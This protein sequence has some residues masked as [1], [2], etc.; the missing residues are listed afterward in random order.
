M[1]ASISAVR[2]VVSDVPPQGYQAPPGAHHMPFFFEPSLTSLQ[3][4]QANLDELKKNDQYWDRR[5][6]QLQRDHE[7]IKDIMDCEYKKAV[8]LIEFLVVRS[9][10]F[11]GFCVFFF[12]I[13][14]VHGSPKGAGD[15]KKMKG[16]P[17]SIKKAAVLECYKQHPNEP[18]LCAKEVSAFTE[19]VDNC[20][21]HFVESRS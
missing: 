17:C 3:I 14:E 18:M 13:A 10:N 12:Q 1:F 6:K 7:Q 15:A 2:P 8:S 9:S 19:C 16:P 21:A 11:D 5:M 4:R 20:R